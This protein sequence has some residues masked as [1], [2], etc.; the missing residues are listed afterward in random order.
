MLGRVRNEQ[1]SFM[2]GIPQGYI[3][4]NL[5]SCN[6]RRRRPKLYTFQHQILTGAQ[7]RRNLLRPNGRRCV[8]TT[9]PCLLLLHKG[10][11]GTNSTTTSLTHNF[12]ER[13]S[14]HHTTARVLTAPSGGSVSSTHL[15]PPLLPPPHSHPKCVLSAVFLTS[16]S[17]PDQSR[18]TPRSLYCGWNSSTPSLTSSSH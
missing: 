7:H 3:H 16:A 18:S 8:D 4:R 15:P 17:S 14:C 13:G 12:V 1:T 6:R 2:H 10:S 11:V 9:H 5:S